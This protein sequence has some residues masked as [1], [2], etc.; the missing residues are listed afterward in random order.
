MLAVSGAILSLGKLRKS[1]VPVLSMEGLVAS[2]L[3]VGTGH[4]HHSTAEV[5]NQMK[6]NISPTHQTPSPSIIVIPV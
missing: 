1:P 2:L 5:G 6:G 3:P 4:Q